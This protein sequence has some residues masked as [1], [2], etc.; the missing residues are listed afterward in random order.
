M[1]RMDRSRVLALLAVAVLGSSAVGSLAG[2]PSAHADSI[3]L[4]EACPPGSQ[5]SSSHAGSWCVPWE[6]W[7]IG[8]CE[9]EE[10]GGRPAHCQALRVCT[11]A[12]AIFQG[13]PS[14]MAYG[15]PQPPLEIDMVVETCAPDG[16][17]DGTGDRAPT[18]GSLR[19]GSRTCTV[20]RLCVVDT[21]PALVDRGRPRT[22]ALA[23][24]PPSA[25]GAPPIASSGWGCRIDGART[26]APWPAL[27]ALL[28]VV[29]VRRRA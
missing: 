12:R 1:R 8:E 18:A 4:P 13:S 7:G 9:A 26:A 5:G 27:V 25:P 10:H 16:A 20:R 17:C 3:G 19:E 14:G 21:L 29:V 28:A 6:C 2:A 22:G 24:S 15:P 23:A 11:E